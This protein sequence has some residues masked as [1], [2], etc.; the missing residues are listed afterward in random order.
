MAEK[1]KVVV[2]DDEEDLCFLVKENLEATG[3]FEVIAVT[4]PLTAETVCKQHKPA[5]VLLDVVMPTR[6]GSDVA[7]ALK[8][9]PL[10]KSIPIIIMSGLGEM[11]YFKD[12]AKWDWLPNRPIV[13]QR[14]EVIDEKVPR[15]AA[16]AYGVDAYISKPFATPDLVETINYL[17]LPAS[18]KD[19]D[20][21]EPGRF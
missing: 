9:D 10:T 3:E 2:I 11:V 14:G 18:E 7:K 6:K 4:D 20:A 5:L 12:K 19:P 13:R 1:K 15:R 17:L 8:K 21:Y 16:E